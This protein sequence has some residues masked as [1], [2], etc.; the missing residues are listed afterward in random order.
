MLLREQEKWWHSYEST[1][2]KHYS[3]QKNVSRTHSEAFVFIGEW[4]RNLKLDQIDILLMPRK[5]DA[6]V[7]ISSRNCASDVDGR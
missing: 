4:R 6:I 7:I 5:S 2:R 1:I 3:L